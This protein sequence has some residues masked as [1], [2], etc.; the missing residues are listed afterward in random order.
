MSIASNYFIVNKKSRRFKMKK[1]VKKTLRTKKKHINSI[2]LICWVIIPL[3]IIV[4]L[5]MDGLGLYPLNTERIIVIGIGVLAVLIPFFSEIT[6]KNFS[7][8]REKNS[9]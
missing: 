9:T 6:I 1:E 8:K 5:I 4:T 7:I 2:N 3:I